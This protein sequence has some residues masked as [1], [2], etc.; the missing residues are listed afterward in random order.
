MTICTFTVTPTPLPQLIAAAGDRLTP[1]ERRIA[2]AV[3]SDPTLLAFGTVSRLA[4]VVG[5]SRPSIIRFAANLGFNGFPQLQD[6]ARQS[7]TREISRPTDRIRQDGD[8]PLARVAMERA[9]ASAF[10]A[11]G[12]AAT[13]DALTD[14]AHRITTANAVWVVSGETSQAGALALVSGLSMVRP[15]VQLLL[16][17]TVGSQL[18]DAAL[19]DI[20]IAIDFQRYRRSLVR[21]AEV[22]TA[23]GIGL[24]AITDGP[25]SPLAGLTPDWF[26]LDVPAVG[27]FD[28]SISSVAFA[29]LIVAAVATLLRDDAT[30]RIDRTEEMWAATDTYHPIEQGPNQAARDNG[31]T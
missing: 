20:A 14:L 16:E 18:S 17:H 29:E 3:V 30:D 7:L 23:E 6:H 9:L 24:V 5:T 31:N 11:V 15:R 2:A 12:R 22:L 19:G 8:T 25:L 21:T 4:E 13:D 1:T 10:E 28:T 27:P 26:E